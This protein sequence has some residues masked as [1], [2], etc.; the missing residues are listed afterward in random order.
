MKSLF[1]I[2]AIFAL[3][4]ANTNFLR[5]LDVTFAAAK[6]SA[7]CIT[8]ATGFTISITD[9]TAGKDTK[10]LVATFTKSSDT[11][12]MGTCLQDSGVSATTKIDCA[13]GTFSS[14]AATG[15]YTLGVTSATGGT[16]TITSAPSLCYTTN[17]LTVASSTS[18]TPSLKYEGDEAANFTITLGAAYTTESAPAVYADSTTLSCSAN[19]E[20]TTL[21]C[22]GTKAT[23]PGGEDGAA[24]NYT[25]TLGECKLYT[26]IVLSVSS[27]SFF[28]FS[29]LLLAILALVLF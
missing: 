21:T 3:S 20:K 17:C 2:V 5:N 11:L 24:K 10:D 14:N 26:G 19:T 23:L 15:N 16:I 4:T 6:Y 7:D 18:K 12:T 8:S 29:G 27:G 13:A 22:S 28:N 9:T 1:I 25:I